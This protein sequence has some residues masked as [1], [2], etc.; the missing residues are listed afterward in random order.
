[1]SNI[2]EDSKLLSSVFIRK[3]GRRANAGNVK[4]SNDIIAQVAGTST[5]EIGDVDDEQDHDDDIYEENGNDE[6]EMIHEHNDDMSTVTSGS[7]VVME[8][9]VFGKHE[10]VRIQSMKS[11]YDNCDAQVKGCIGK[12]V[13]LKIYYMMPDG[14]ISTHHSNISAGHLRLLDDAEIEAANNAIGIIFYIIL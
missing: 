13:H 5:F 14:V 7:M 10:W 2:D 4:H 3:N 6:Q 12:I 8:S 11:K 9:K 1:M